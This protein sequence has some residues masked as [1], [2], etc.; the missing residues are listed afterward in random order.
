MTFEQAQDLCKS[1]FDQKVVDSRLEF[2][3]KQIADFN[4]K[5]R[6][7]TDYYHRLWTQLKENLVACV[8]LV[9]KRGSGGAEPS[10]AM[11]FQYRVD[12]GGVPES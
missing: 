3:R 10:G 4:V 5:S 7:E 9:K 8:A 12:F 2:L 1:K 11:S 6:A